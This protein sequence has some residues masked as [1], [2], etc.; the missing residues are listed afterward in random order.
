MMSAIPAAALAARNQP[1]EFNA[2]AHT[3]QSLPMPKA[4][5][6]LLKK[7]LNTRSPL[8]DEIR[9]ELNGR[10]GPNKTWKAVCTKLSLQPAFK[11]LITVGWVKDIERGGNS[12]DAPQRFLNNFEGLPDSTVGN[13]VK[14]L[15][16][17]DS[18]FLKISR[19]ILNEV[20]ASEWDPANSNL[21]KCLCLLDQK[22]LRLIIISRN[23]SNL[24]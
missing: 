9:K 13:F 14:A 2:A 3:V 7:F 21:L 1:A 17:A 10:H 11:G 23:S 12:G 19:E 24:I 6:V 22:K 15:V 16:D 20:G 5:E 18:C 4:L 8:I